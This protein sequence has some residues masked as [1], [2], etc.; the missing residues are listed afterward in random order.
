MSNFHLNI[1]TIFIGLDSRSSRLSYVRTFAA[2]CF[3]SFSHYYLKTLRNQYEDFGKCQTLKLFNPQIRELPDNPFRSTIRTK[4]WKFH[5]RLWHIFAKKPL[6]L[7]LMSPNEAS[8]MNHN[9]GLIMVSKGTE[10]WKISI[11]I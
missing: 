10:T 4:T 9:S 3:D 8:C 1:W 5:Y 6:Q 11:P 2:E 7:T